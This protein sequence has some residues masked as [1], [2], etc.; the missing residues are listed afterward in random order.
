MLVCLYLFSERLG[1]LRF[2]GRGE[3][4][5]IKSIEDILNNASFLKI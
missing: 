3:R 2:R 1:G 4:L 5:S